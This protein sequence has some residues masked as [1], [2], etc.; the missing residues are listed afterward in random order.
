MN[1]VRLAE[2]MGA[3]VDP[4]LYFRKLRSLARLA[5][6]AGRARHDFLLKN[7]RLELQHGFLLERAAEIVVPIGTL[8]AGQLVL[9]EHSNEEHLYEWAGR[10]LETIREALE[11]DRPQTV[12][13]RFGELPNNSEC[14]FFWSTSRNL[15]PAQ[16]LRIGSKLLRAIPGAGLTI[17]NDRPPPMSV[18]EAVELL[19]ANR[20]LDLARIGFYE[21]NSSL[22]KKTINPG[23]ERLQNAPE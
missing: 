16:Q 4:E 19:R 20:K 11:S 14:D 12:P 3:P 8:E 22:P 23:T 2:Q 18:G 9:G 15:L 6:S 7:G 10:T 13:T 17:R 5:K 21:K 1:L